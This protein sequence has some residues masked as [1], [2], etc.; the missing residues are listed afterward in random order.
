MNGCFSE[1]P[2]VY[3]RGHIPSVRIAGND[4]KHFVF[5]NASVIG[6]AITLATIV[7]GVVI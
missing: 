4:L 6:L 3:G 7:F 1:L 5:S 2:S